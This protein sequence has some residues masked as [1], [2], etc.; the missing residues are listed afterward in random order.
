MVRYVT[1]AEG[2]RRVKR[3]RD[4]ALTGVTLLDDLCSPSEEV[5][6]RFYSP[7]VG[8]K[9]RNFLVATLGHFN[10][11]SFVHPSKFFVWDASSAATKNCAIGADCPIRPCINPGNFAHFF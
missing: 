11:S 9:S 5:G 7:Q 10:V 6:R 1:G 4:N 2:H 3:R 8:A